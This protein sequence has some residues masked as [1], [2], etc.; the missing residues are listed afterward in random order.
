MSH[1]TLSAALSPNSK[2]SVIINAA[3]GSTSDISTEL[4]DVLEAKGYAHIAM[5]YCEPEELAEA[6]DSVTADST[7]LLIVYGGDGTCKSGAITARGAGVP[8]IALPGGTMNILPKALYATVDWKEA[9]EL[10]LSQ[11]GPRWLPAGQ[12]NGE[13]FFV[14]LIIGDPIKMAGVR[15]NLR[16]GEVVEAVRLVPEVIEA[17]TSGKTFYYKID[18]TEYQRGANTMLLSCPHMSEGAIAADAFELATVPQMSLGSIIGIGAKTLLQGW[19]D[20]THVRV[21]SVKTVEITGQGK[22][23]ILLDGEAEQVDCPLNISLDLRG[24]QVLAPDIKTQL[25]DEL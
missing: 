7:D 16:G 14:A 21:G 22:F 17:V 11:S 12:I 10:A 13:V 9:L 15:E 5:H 1:K 20:S 6:F 24:V 3:S 25:S 4:K 23:D 19:R 2:I 8:F 18:G